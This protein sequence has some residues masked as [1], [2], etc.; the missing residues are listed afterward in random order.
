MYIVHMNDALYLFKYILELDR[1]IKTIVHKTH[2]KSLID[3][4]YNNL[5][6]TYFINAYNEQKHLASPEKSAV[7]TSRCADVSQKHLASII[8]YDEFLINL[9]LATSGISV[10]FDN[11][12]IYGQFV[13]DLLI[14]KTEQC[15]EI[16]VASHDI[17]TRDAFKKYLQLICDDD[18]FCV[19][20][21]NNIKIKVHK[22][23]YTC[24][25]EILLEC[26]NN[27]YGVCFDGV[28][29][30]MHP[31]CHMK[32]MYNNISDSDIFHIKTDD[33]ESISKYANAVIHNEFKV[34]EQLL[35]RITINHIDSYIIDMLYRICIYFDKYE[36]IDVLFKNKY[37]PPID[38]IFDAIRDDKIKYINLLLKHKINIDVLNSDGFSPIEYALNIYANI[39][40]SES[41]DVIKQTILLL[42]KCKYT[43]NPKWWDLVNGIQIY[44]INQKSDYD[45]YIYQDIKESKINSIKQLNNCIVRH[46][47][48][49][50]MVT[51]LRCFVR[52][53]IKFID[54]KDLFNVI[55]ESHSSEILNYVEQYIPMSDDLIMIYFELR[56]YEK[57][58]KIPDKINMENT[59][60]HLIKQNDIKGLVFIFEY[61]DKTS[62]KRIYSNGNTLLHLLCIHSNERSDVTLEKSTTPQ[63][64]YDTF[65]CLRVLLNY[66]PESI[67]ISNNDGNIPI[68]LACKSNY[69]NELLLVENSDIT[70]TNSYG[71][72]YL[73]NIIRNGSIDVLNK[74]FMCGVIQKNN[75][76]DSINYNN[77][78]ALILASKLQNQDYCN[79]LIDYGADLDICDC[80]GN[81]I[82]HYIGLYCL[83]GINIDT[84]SDKKNFVGLT[85][86]DYIVRH[87]CNKV[88]QI[89]TKR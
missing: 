32:L 41:N 25:Q 79:M 16:V 13:Y 4:I 31:L 77:E 12:I 49:F 28:D 55:T 17:S 18:I 8:S 69:I 50:R 70:K 9:S 43:R 48:K 86:T 23:L 65:R 15:N 33:I 7:P 84:I 66:F 36:Y 14:G 54:M 5:L 63:I 10:L 72:T 39:V 38:T 40:N 60:N 64:S 74:V 1:K 88:S 73:H 2:S 53:N 42:N 3:E 51:D 11:C 29:V 35:D 81:S 62:P 46:L 78:T 22:K 24:I 75:L 30:I 58:I 52:H 89:N 21:L 27:I 71:D 85:P 37:N 68:F 6:N 87:V 76:I 57:I 44:N 47:I 83:S 19:Y 20:Q 61:I 56:L 34:F 82:Y 59:L 45:K 67:N 26:E 80:Y